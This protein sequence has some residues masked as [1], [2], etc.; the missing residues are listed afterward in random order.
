[1]AAF[2]V[3]KLAA[4][5]LR[6]ISKPIAN[7]AKQKAKSSYFMRNYVCMPPAQCKLAQSVIFQLSNGF[8]RKSDDSSAS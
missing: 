3:A 2:P 8:Y 6:Q 7:Y 4:V 5:L 1:M